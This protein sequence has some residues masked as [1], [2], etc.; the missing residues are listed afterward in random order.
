MEYRMKGSS[1]QQKVSTLDQAEPEPTQFKEEPDELCINQAEE[2]LLLNQDADVHVELKSEYEENFGDCKK[3]MFQF[4][5][6]SHYHQ[7]IRNAETELHK[8]DVQQ[9]HLCEDEDEW[10]LHKQELHTILDQAESEPPQIKEEPEELCSDQEREQL[11]LNQGADVKV[12]F[13]S[14]LLDHQHQP[15]NIIMIPIIKLERIGIS[16]RETHL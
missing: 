1:N 12:E 6:L 11:L 2:S 10:H 3:M 5:E 16:I 15:R 9:Q 14:D 8:T 13:K 4:K 7:R